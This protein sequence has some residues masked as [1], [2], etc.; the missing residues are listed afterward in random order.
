VVKAARTAGPLSY[1]SAQLI[2][3]VRVLTKRTCALSMPTRDERIVDV[4]AFDRVL[5][6]DL[7]VAHHDRYH[8]AFQLE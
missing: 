6:L 8:P 4:M 3:R 1:L 7:D 5:G 2:L